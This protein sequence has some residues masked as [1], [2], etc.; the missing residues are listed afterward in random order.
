M[1]TSMKEFVQKAEIQS[2]ES[3]NRSYR[4]IDNLHCEIN[5]LNELLLKYMN[6]R[7][8]YTLS[9][10]KKQREMNDIRERIPEVYNNINY[11]KECINVEK[12]E[13]KRIHITYGYSY[14]I[15][16][17]YYTE[18]TPIH[19]DIYK[20]ENYTE[21]ELDDDS[22]NEYVPPYTEEDEE[23]EEIKDYRYNHATGLFE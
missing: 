18:N 6:K 12:N 9:Y 10:S 13:M 16:P 4:E 11:Y 23:L 17:Q 21:Y 1:K 7:A 20:P 3:I 19:Y 2:R 5:F 8:G 15:K 22:E 14:D